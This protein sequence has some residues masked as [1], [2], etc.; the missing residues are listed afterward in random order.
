SL[1]CSAVRRRCLSYCPGAPLDLHSF[2]TRRSSDLEFGEAG[3]EQVSDRI[4]RCGMIEVE[5][6]GGVGAHLIGGGGDIIPCADRPDIAVRSEEHTSELQ[7]RENLVCRLLLEKK[8]QIGRL[9]D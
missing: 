9:E 2:P 1:H 6:N 7:S 5:Q 4:G 3:R 8:K